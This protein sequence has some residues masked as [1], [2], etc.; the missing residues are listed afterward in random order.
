MEYI[1]PPLNYTGSKY[2]LLEQLLPEMD[3]TKEYF[4]DLFAGGGS[5]YT[6]IV[7]EYNKVLVNDIIEDLI[8]IHKGL[9]ETDNI[10]KKTK[11]LCPSKE[12]K[13]WIKMVQVLWFQVL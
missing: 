3:Y 13:N 12:V 5:V 7:D 1:N 11:L 8:V 10:I 2:K 6:N 4:V 9:L